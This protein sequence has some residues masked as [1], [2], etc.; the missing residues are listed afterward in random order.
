VLALPPGCS[1]RQESRWTAAPPGLNKGIQI[2]I[3]FSFS[4]FFLT[5]WNSSRLLSNSPCKI[6]MFMDE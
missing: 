2:L 5:H 3:I 1:Q 6:A 4:F